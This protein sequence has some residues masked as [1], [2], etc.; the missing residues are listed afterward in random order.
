MMTEDHPLLLSF[1]RELWLRQYPRR[2]WY[3]RLMFWHK[4]KS[5]PELLQFALS[6]FAIQQLRDGTCEM[7]D[8]R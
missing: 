5:L 3:R 7:F 8:G 6:G 1:Y 4:P 2:R